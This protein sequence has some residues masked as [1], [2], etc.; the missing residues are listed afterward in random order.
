[1]SYKLIVGDNR[2]ILASA[3]T[4][5][6]DGKIKLIYIDPPYNTKTAKSYNDARDGDEWEKNIG[7]ALPLL[8]RLLR[9]DGVIFIS[10][11]DNEYAELKLICDKI[12]SRANFLGALITR[13]AQRSNSKHINTVHEY[14]LCYAKDKSLVKR[15]FVKRVDIPEQREMIEDIRRQTKVE[16]RRGRA[17]AEKKL[18]EL[19]DYYCAKNEIT[20]LKNYNR[21][22]EDGEVFFASDLSVPGEPRE[23]DIP[24]IN[25]RLAP[26]KTRSWTSDK[27]FIELARRGLL[28]FRDGRPYQKKYLADAEDNVPSILNFYSRHGSKDLNNLGLRDLFDTPKPVELIKFLIRIAD[29]GDGE[30]VLDCYAGSG[31][32]GQAVMEVNKEDGKKINFLLIQRK[33]KIAENSAPYKACLARGIEPW[34]SETTKLRLRKVMEKLGLTDQLEIIEP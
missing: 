20:W 27:R 1:M 14:A 22:D 33:E 24:E 16:V 12:F 10:I 21:V 4:R 7:E 15:F 26:L 8:R 18:R 28:A 19:I 31:T 6:Y 23:V 32:T 30:T 11:D 25:L 34:I 5:E 17:A 2:E 3:A 9:E 29:V 13:Q